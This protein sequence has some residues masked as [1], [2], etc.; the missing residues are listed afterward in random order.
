MIATAVS[1]LVTTVWSMATGG[2]FALAFTVMLIAA[3]PAAPPLSVTEAVTVW[4]PTLKVLV[5]NDDAVVIAPSRLEVHSR[6]PEM[7]PSG[8]SIAVPLKVIEVPSVT[9]W[10]SAGEVIVTTGA[11]GTF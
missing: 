6:S 7:L 8:S 11:A 2:V 4:L 3:D 10:P 5:E 1:A 9:V